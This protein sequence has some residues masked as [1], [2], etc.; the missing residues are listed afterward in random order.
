[1][2][3]LH[4]TLTRKK[5]VFKPL[6]DKKV[7]LYTC[8]PTVYDEAHIGNLRSYIFA[9][10][11]RRALEYNGYRVK[12][13]MNITDVDDKTIKRAVDKYGVKA[14]P[15]ELRRYT[16]KY[17]VDFK[18]DLK[19][20]NIPT[21]SRIIN[22][23]RVSDKIEEIKKF[24]KKLIKLGYAYKT[25]DGV[26]FSIEKYQKKFS[27]Y[28]N[29]VGKGFLKGKKVGARVKV[30][31]YEKENLSDFALWKNRDAS[32]GNIFWADKE[33]GDG[34]PG[35]HIECSVINRAAFGD[36]PTDIHTGG[37]DLVFPHHTNEIAQSQPF[38]KPFARYWMHCEHLLANGRKMAKRER[39]FYTLKDLE[40]EVP[41]AGLVFRYLTLLTH[42]RMQMNFTI[43]SLKAAHSGLDNLSE[44]RFKASGPDHIGKGYEDIFAYFK[45]DL[46]DD[47]N[48]AEALGVLWQLAGHKGSG[49]RADK[50]ANILG[51]KF[52]KR[53]KVKIPQKI[54]ELAARRETLRAN[55]QFIQADALRKKIE[56]LGYKVEDTPYGPK[57]TATRY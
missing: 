17:L 52:L 27:D 50:M 40:K 30:D 18:K 39:N 10:I 6:R 26:Y 21:E 45:K 3:K 32:D 28:G 48:T 16:N 43:K 35:W 4:N 8:G 57:I 31:E 53:K 55:K 22:F 56:S 23:I 41:N 54:R 19:A 44:Q 20:V 25:E 37:V 13:V 47:L 11:L 29:L 36:A 46:N 5:E 38:Y 7:G 2:L 51:L 42:Y 33:L 12:W 15:K 24:I 14:T 1:M 49:S 34:R 9:D